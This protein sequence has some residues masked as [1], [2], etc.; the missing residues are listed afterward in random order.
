M[1]L[2]KLQTKIMQDDKK[3]KVQ[4]TT[5]STGPLS[6]QPESDQLLGP[7]QKINENMLK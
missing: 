6:V 4:L 5:Q 1:C 7:L 3:T 2:K